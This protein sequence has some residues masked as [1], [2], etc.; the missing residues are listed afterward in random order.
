M[1]SHARKIN[2]LTENEKKYVRILYDHQK[3]Q[4]KWE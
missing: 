2:L 4:V 1:L 3:E